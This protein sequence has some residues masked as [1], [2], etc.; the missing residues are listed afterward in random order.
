MCSTLSKA[1]AVTAVFGPSIIPVKVSTSG[2]GRVACSPNCSKR[3][4]AGTRLTLRAIAAKGWK[5]ARW[6]GACTGA[7]LICTPKTDYAVT[8]RANFKKKH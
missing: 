1:A 4:S 3:F 7:R 8:V 6:G 5:F 2:Q